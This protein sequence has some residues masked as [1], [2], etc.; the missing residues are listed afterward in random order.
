MEG[1]RPEARG[2]KEAAVSVD[3]HFFKAFIA[4]VRF[5]AG[6]FPG[7][8]SAASRRISAAVFTGRLP[9]LV[10]TRLG[11]PLSVTSKLWPG[12]SDFAKAG[13]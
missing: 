1:V 12:R 7:N 3:V 13:E 10:T 2:D 4:A 5:T 11:V 6:R 8:I 9:A